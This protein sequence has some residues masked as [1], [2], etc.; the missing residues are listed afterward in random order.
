MLFRERIFG[1]GPSLPLRMSPLRLLAFQKITSYADVG[2][3][4]GWYEGDGG[5]VF[6]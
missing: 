2:H 1:L 5:W 6:A 3:G 4:G